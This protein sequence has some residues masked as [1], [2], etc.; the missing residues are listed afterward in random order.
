MNFKNLKLYLLA[1][2]TVFSVSQ[3]IS[4]DEA[5][6]PFMNYDAPKR[7]VIREIRME[8][9]ESLNPDVLIISSGMS[10]GDTIYIPGDYITDATRKLWSQRMF[11]DIKVVVEEDGEYADIVFYLKERPRVYSWKFEGLK[12]GDVTELTS[13]L[14]LGHGTELSEY[15]INFAIE[16]IKGYLREKSFLNA[17][18][19]VIQEPDPEINNGV[20][21]TFRV[22]KGKKVKV[23]DVTFS[24]NDTFKDK[25]L[26]K[27]L[28]K[29]KRK[30]ANIFVSSKFKESQYEEDKEN[31]IDFLNSKGYRNA[32]I[33]SDSLYDIND[34]RIGI[35]INLEEGNK[36]YYRNITWLG[37][38]KLS[39]E[40]LDRILSIKEGDTYDNQTMN[41][42]L[43][44]SKDSDPDDY[45]VMT[46]YQDDGYLFFQ[47][48]PLETVVSADSIDV[49]IKMVEG[50]Q[51]TINRV[52]LTGNESVNDQV[53]R[54]ELDVLPGELYNRSLLVSSARRLAM[55]GHFNPENVNPDFAIISNELVDI[56]FDL[57]EQPNDQLEISGGWGASTFVGSIGVVLNNFS[58]QNMFRKGEWRP[59]PKGD[60]QQ[61]ALHAQSNGT[62]YSAVSLTFT[63]PWLGG[64]KPYS[65]T[66]GLY[67]SNYTNAYYAWQ[68]GSQHFRTL[69]ASVGFGRRLNWPDRNF[70]LYH[71]LMYQSYNLKDWD[72]FIISDG[73]SNIIALKTVFSRNT[74]GQ[75]I[76]PR[77]GSELSVSLT[78][79][80]PY[81]LFDGKDYKSAS[82]SDQSRYKMIEY[83]K[84]HFLADWYFPLDAR[85][86]LVIRAKAELGFIGSYNKHK[87]SP[88]EGYEVGGDGLSGY[89]LYGVD[90]IGLRGYGN[91]ALTPNNAYARA[92]NK[93]TL[94]L[95]YP[96]VLKPSST[97]YGLVFAEGGNAFS[98]VRNIDPFLLKRSLGFGLRVYLPIV[99]MIGADWGYGF[100]RAQNGAGRKGE[101]HFLIGQ[102]F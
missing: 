99:G 69:G 86:N 7:F 48:E 23:G 93:Y 82:L 25:T 94:E 47:M 78:L 60:G 3:S 83:H 6:Y 87:P 71:E 91:A 62:Y 44:I 37:N 84:W 76:Y 88:F 51:A 29:T 95:R 1:F 30:N 101:I 72:S 35:H 11:A 53:I 74:L 4:Q 79:T 20:N 77:T 40:E 92:Y 100:D 80:P 28:K 54:R 13:K 73:T 26:R 9:I 58:I 61:L 33:V 85:G 43:G 2:I 27:A 75:P 59:Y 63:E 42:R 5:N 98:E 96:F 24:G 39:T 38:S 67:Y 97:I 65:F 12:K 50:R 8:G 18:V 81:S 10:V 57:E 55:I 89:N 70:S 49:E 46:L 32:V 17:V 14:N 52:I 36:F 45:S 90:V 22:D 19:E 16:T 15:R 34:K 68:S 102:Q 31:L 21:I 41:K 64:K 56:S 66:V